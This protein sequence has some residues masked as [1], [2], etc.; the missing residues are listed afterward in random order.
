MNISTVL[1]FVLSIVGIILSK[2]A[3]T[4]CNKLCIS[5]TEQCALLPLVSFGFTAFAIVFLGILLIESVEPKKV[6]KKEVK[7]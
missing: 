7:S 4:D 5:P 3:Y 1:L 6:E 2:M